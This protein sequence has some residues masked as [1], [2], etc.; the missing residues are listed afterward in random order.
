MDDERSVKTLMEGTAGEGRIKGRG[1][2]RWIDYVEFDLGNIVFEK[3]EIMS[4]GQKSLEGKVRLKGMLG[5]RR[6]KYPVYESYSV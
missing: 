6:I 1:R 4:L 5:E 3:M 2:L